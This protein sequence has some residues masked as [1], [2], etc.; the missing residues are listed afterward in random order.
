LYKDAQLLREAMKSLAVPAS[1]LLLTLARTLHADIPLDK[2]HQLILDRGLQIQG[3]VMPFDQFHLDTLYGANYTSPN[4]AWDSNTDWM[5]AAPGIPWGRWLHYETESDLKPNE[6][7][8]KSQLLS[9]CIGEEQDL[10]DP[11]VRQNTIDWFNNNRAKF[12]NTLLYVNSWGSQIYNNNLPDFITGGKPDMISFDTYPWGTPTGFAQFCTDANKYR[13]IAN[14]FGIPFSVYLQTFHDYQYRDTSASELRL[15]QF[16]AWTFGAQFANTFTY[17]SGAS[18]LFDNSMGGDNAPN[19]RYDAIKETTRQSRNLGPAL[20]RL[21]STDVRFVP[22]RHM[23]NGVNTLNAIPY[24]LT[25]WS[26]GA[27]GD[28]HITAVSVR[29]SSEL[30]NTLKGDILLGF[31]KVLREDMDGPAANEQYFMVTNALVDPNG[32]PVQTKQTIDL[33]FDF[34]GT[35]IN[36]L[37]R[38]SRLTGL[39][40]VVPLTSLGGTLYKFSL[41]FEGGTG[42]L[43]KYND[44]APFVGIDAIPEPALSFLLLPVLLLI[45]RSRQNSHPSDQPAPL[46]TIAATPAATP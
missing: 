18:S 43:F 12:P 16:A 31:F 46:C 10:N 14:A 23:E 2:G 17:N 28:S 26:P 25:N 7:P 41:V 39:T 19:F 45:R 33:T 4:F 32:T 34:A 3:T 37:L 35:T 9:L 5:G 36:S 8:Y 6:Q 21:V 44:G 20:I 27:G 40:E 22:G 1:I 11:T 42:E 13:K 38:L 15:N 24:D 29:S 30:N